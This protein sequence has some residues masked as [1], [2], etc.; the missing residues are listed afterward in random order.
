[1]PR[2]MTDHTLDAIKGWPSP[3]AVDYSAKFKAADI[4]TLAAAGT[5]PRAGRVVT[6]DSNGDFVYGMADYQ[7]PLFLFASQNDPDV[8]NAGGD[9]AGT[10]A[11]A[12]SWVPIVPNGKLLALVATGGYELETTEF[13]AA[14]YVYNE[15]L[16]AA[17]GTTD[18]SSGKLVTVA[19][20]AAACC[21]VVSR[22]T[23]TNAYGR[24]VLAFWPVFKPKAS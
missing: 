1:M 5:E 24:S 14:T 16:K 18:A 23:R 17:T 4:V 12:G 19:Q 8:S 21:G 13:V 15:W 22:P 20:G 7:M 10:A 3:Y 2:Q 11:D 9:P 6:L